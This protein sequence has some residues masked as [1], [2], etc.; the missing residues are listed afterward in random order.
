M[1]VDGDGIMEVDLADGTENLQEDRPRRRGSM[2]EE[3][4]R[5]RR[6]NSYNR[7]KNNNK[8]KQEKSKIYQKNKDVSRMKKDNQ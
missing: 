6:D 4:E 3:E 7:K 2:S 5:Q 1:D 8:E